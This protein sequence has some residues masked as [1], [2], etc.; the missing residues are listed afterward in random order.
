VSF[1]H[2]NRVYFLF[3][4]TWRVGESLAS[5]FDWDSIAFCTDPSAQAGLSLTFYKQPPLVPG[6]SQGAFEVPLDGF[7]FEEILAAVECSAVNRR[8]ERIFIERCRA[9]AA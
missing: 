7:S 2:K 4:D 3:G 5:H 6:I 1:E 9:C 8:Q